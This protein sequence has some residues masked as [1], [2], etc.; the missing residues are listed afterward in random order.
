MN[1]DNQH[2]GPNGAMNDSSPMTGFDSEIPGIL[3]EKTK[4]SPPDGQMEEI[5]DVVI[6]AKPILQGG[7]Q[8]P[9]GIHGK[10]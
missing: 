6:G 7:M 8:Y 9:V 4:Y 10:K 1:L 3:K 2:F 5:I